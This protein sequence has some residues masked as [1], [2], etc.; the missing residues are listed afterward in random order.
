[1]GTLLLLPAMRVSKKHS[2]RL[3]IKRDPRPR[4]EHLRVIRDA[5]ASIQRSER[6]PSLGELAVVAGLS[7]FYFQRLFVRWMGITP[8]EYAAAWQRDRLVRALTRGLPVLQAI[9]AA[10]YSST[11][12]VYGR[13]AQLLGMTPAQVRKGARDVRIRYALSPCQ[14]AWLLVATTPRG[15]CILEL[16]A[17]PVELL[18][19][20]ATRF[21]HAQLAEGSAAMAVVVA[22]LA[23]GLSPVPHTRG[24]PREIRMMA[25][26]QR[27]W[28]LLDRIRFAAITTYADVDRILPQLD[29]VAIGLEDSHS[30]AMTRNPVIIT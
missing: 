24:L 21:P 9:Y 15:L 18:A 11:S 20:L 17:S 12:R 14:G 22:L 4:A 7:L 8:R 26:R 19:L 30:A 28:V 10:G 29:G 25:L 27:M 13:L 16:G 3:S 6:P 1:M 2:S 5:C 23:S